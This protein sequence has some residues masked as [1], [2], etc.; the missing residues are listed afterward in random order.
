MELIYLK[1]LTAKIT[2]M[3][4]ETRKEVIHLLENNSDESEAFSFVCHK[5]KAESGKEWY[6]HNG[7]LILDKSVV[8]DIH[9][10]V[11]GDLKIN[12]YYDDFKPGSSIGNVIVLGNMEANHILTHE[13][14]TITGD[15]VV[16]GII[17]N[18]YNDWVFES[19][20]KISC[21]A[22]YVDDKDTLCNYDLLSAD[23]IR[24]DDGVKGPKITDFFVNDLL[25]ENNDWEEYYEKDE[26]NEY[27]SLNIDKMR[28]F[29]KNGQEIFK[30]K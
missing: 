24:N 16:K 17:L 10:V 8:S 13:T 14:L 12:G 26:V 28:D 22:F 6:V 27:T 23:F 20:G 4:E 5:L 18:V 29:I 3:D 2:P 21:K 19:I 11:K 9:L 7:D 30:H 1:D 25:K 15:I